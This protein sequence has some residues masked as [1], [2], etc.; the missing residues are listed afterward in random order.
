MIK[1]MTVHTKSQPTH[2]RISVFYRESAIHEIL[3]DSGVDETGGK[4]F[5]FKKC[6][7]CVV[8]V[9][10]RKEEAAAATMMM[11]IWS[12]CLDILTHVCKYF[13]MHRWWQAG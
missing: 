12:Q 4:K 7:K 1:T 11:K 13:I 2:Q 3:S 9:W 10:M 6:I 5:Q 8:D